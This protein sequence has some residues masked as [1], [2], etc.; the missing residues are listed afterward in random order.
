MTWKRYKQK[1]RISIYREKDVHIVEAGG[2]GILGERE[3]E[4]GK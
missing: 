1:K 2:K 4:R 3:R